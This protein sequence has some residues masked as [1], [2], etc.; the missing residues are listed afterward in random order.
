MLSLPRPSYLRQA[1]VELGLRRDQLRL[2]ASGRFRPLV[3]LPGWA[4]R[5]R[6]AFPPLVEMIGKGFL[7][8]PPSSGFLMP[9]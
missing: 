7:S 1:G 9:F 3:F 4:V 5:G 2:W 8:I 6:D